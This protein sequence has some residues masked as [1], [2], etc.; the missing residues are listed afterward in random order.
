VNIDEI[1]RNSHNSE[2]YSYDHMKKTSNLPLLDLGM[3]IK[4]ERKSRSLTQTQLGELTETS[5]NFISQ[6]EA[7]KATAHIGKV[8]RALPA[9]A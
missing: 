7:G 8:L 9:W 1:H 2:L 6:I 4:N 5:I 3:T